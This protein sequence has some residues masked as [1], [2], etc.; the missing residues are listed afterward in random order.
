MPWRVAFA[1]Q[2]DGWWL[3]SDI[4]WHKPNPM[5]ESVRDRPTKAHEYIFL[6]TRSRSY[7]FDQDAVREPQ[8]SR[9]ERHEGRSGY[10]EGHPSKGG[11]KVRRLHPAG[12][13]IRSVWRISPQ[14]FPEAH[15]AA[16]P[17]RLVEPCIKAGTSEKGCCP[18]C[19][20]PWRRLLGPARPAKGRGSG[21]R[22]RR[23]RHERDGPDD[24]LGSSVPWYPA[25]A[26]TIGWQ[27]SC[28]CNAGGPVPCTVL[29]PFLGAGT[30]ALVALKL[31]RAA[32][33]VE[34]NPEYARMTRQRLSAA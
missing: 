14:A 20:A 28:E 11:I 33:G 4:V 8:R 5:P 22:Q 25:A 23:L 10:R 17:E 15:F 6:L 29:D 2:A 16:F 19:G 13:N 1:L 9:G 27:P 24:H 7:F 31:G 34:L 26:R 18:K 12:R 30:T 21:N 32:I 3:R